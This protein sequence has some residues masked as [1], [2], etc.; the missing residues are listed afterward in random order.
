[1]HVTITNS[2]VEVVDAF[3]SHSISFAE[4]SGRRV[5]AGRGVSGMYI[6]RRGKSRVF[7]RESSL[8]L[9]D[10]YK[11]WKA[12]I[13]DLDKADMLKRKSAGKEGPMDWFVADDREQRP[14]IGGPDSIA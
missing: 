7:V 13:Y 2:Q 1:M 11:R 12:S 4:I 8:R 5:A 10:F 14:A 6:Y 3:S 9:D